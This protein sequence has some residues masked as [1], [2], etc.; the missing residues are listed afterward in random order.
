M[1]ALEPGALRFAVLDLRFNGGGDYTN[2]L[3]FT[4]ELPRRI[5]ADGKLFIVTDN[6]TFSAAIVTMARAKHFAGARAVVVGEHVGD[7]ERF[8][9]ESGA[10]LELPN[11]KILV[12]FATGYHDWGR[13][14]QWS[15]IA[16]CFW[17]NLAYDVPA[18]SL[19]PDKPLAWR[20][21]D[22]RNGVDTVMKE[23]VREAADRA[24][25]PPAS[26]G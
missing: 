2:T 13:G 9:A 7:R 15:D 12:F 23:I 8:W 5:A 22:Y 21:A 14:C 11:S 6:A 3:R 17:L 24:A 16:R 26:G 19:A 20:F 4:K 18:G 25:S 1:N 10:P